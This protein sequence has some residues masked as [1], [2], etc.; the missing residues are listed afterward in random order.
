MIKIGAGMLNTYDVKKYAKDNNKVYLSHVVNPTIVGKPFQAK[1]AVENGLTSR[2]ILAFMSIILFIISIIRLVYKHFMSMPVW[3][4]CIL[5]IIGAFCLVSVRRPTMHALIKYADIEN[6][7]DI[8]ILNKPNNDDKSNN[9]SFE[10]RFMN[11]GKRP[12][13][14]FRRFTD[15]ANIVRTGY[16]DLDK[17]NAILG[18]LVEMDDA[19]ETWHDFGYSL[20]NQ[21]NSENS[22]I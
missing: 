7:T 9:E 11:D 22:K 4:A 8:T 1:P 19:D 16:I 18:Y 2:V 3:V 12:V 13:I 6:N 15:N 21:Y 17:D 10:A 20:I 14:L 5:M